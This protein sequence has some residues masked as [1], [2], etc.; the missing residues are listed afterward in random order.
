MKLN[1]TKSD[2]IFLGVVFGG[3][4][5]VIIYIVATGYKF[6]LEGV[7]QRW[8]YQ[9]PFGEGPLSRINPLTIIMTWVVMGIVIFMATRVKVFKLVPGKK[10]SL[11]EALL[12][13][14]YDL[15]KDS[16]SR[17]EFVRPIFDIAASLFLFVIVSNFIGSFPGINAIPLESGEVKFT[18][19]SDSWYA[20]TSDLNMNLMLAFFVFVMSHVYAIKVK[21]WKSWGKSFF[22][23]IW[24]M[25]PINIIGEIAKPLSHALR[26]FGNI[27]GGSI[28]ILILGYLV[29]Y[30]VLPAALWG[31]F[32]LF[33]GAIQALIFT[34]LAIAYISSL[35]E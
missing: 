32:G 3:Y 11:L 21:G 20:P 26:L 30:F 23:P 19:L 4:V 16:V 18:I 31:I 34:I 10:Q 15:V 2:K 5:A 17:K 8:I 22:E 12:D 1:L 9:L 14:I 13:Y 35:I 29:K 7:G 24:W 33:F 28:L 25:F 27:M 6:Q